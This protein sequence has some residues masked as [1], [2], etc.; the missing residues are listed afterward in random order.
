MGNYEVLKRFRLIPSFLIFDS[1]VC[2]GTPS[3]AA[4]PARAETRPSASRSAF[5]SSLSHVLQGLWSTQSLQ[6][7]LEPRA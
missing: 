2:L 4:A 3:F 7:L 5:R 1:S 6:Q